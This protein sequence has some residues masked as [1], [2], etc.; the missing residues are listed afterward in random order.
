MSYIKY[1]EL[2]FEGMKNRDSGFCTVVAVATICNLSYKRAY[3]KMQKLGRR[4][5]QGAYAGTYHQAIKNQGYRIEGV[6]HLADG[7]R[8]L[9][10]AQTKYTDGKYLIQTRGHISASVNGDLNDWANPENNTRKK[11]S[12]RHVLT[13]SKC[14]YIGKTTEGDI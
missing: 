8:T 4:H 13:V 14:I 12:M 3:K 11:K 10:Q 5:R 9:G 2:E 6:D 1:K 7:V